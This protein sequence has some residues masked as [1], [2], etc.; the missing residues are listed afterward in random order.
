[1][2][3]AQSAV[4]PLRAGMHQVQHHARQLRQRGFEL[5]AHGTHVR[6]YI[7]HQGLAH[8]LQ[9]LGQAVQPA[10]AG[11]LHGAA[12]LV[13]GDRGQVVRL[14]KHQQAVV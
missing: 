10:Q 2:G 7:Q 6:V 9:D 14:V 1:M 3:K 13:Q 8:V 5:A 4:L 12:K 11:Q